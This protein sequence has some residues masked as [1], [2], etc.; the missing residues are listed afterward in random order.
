MGL[1]SDIDIISYCIDCECRD[2]DTETV[3]EVFY[4]GE[5]SVFHSKKKQ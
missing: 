4:D 2:R 3:P 1:D 5:M